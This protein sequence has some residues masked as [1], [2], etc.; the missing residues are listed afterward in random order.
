MNKINKIITGTVLLGQNKGT[1]TGARTANLDTILAKDLNKGLYSC[2]VILDKNE[3]A[4]LLFF[5]HNSLSDKDCLEV[6]IL[7]FDK[8]IY[9][10]QIN[11]VINKFL[12]PEIKFDNIDDLKKQIKKDLSLI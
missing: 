6:H 12:R 1:L 5:G 7:N 4:G 11:I 8:D 9:G 3:Y 10:K 2:K